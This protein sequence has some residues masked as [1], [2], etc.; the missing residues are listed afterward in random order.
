MK[1]NLN[2]DMDFFSNNA[3]RIVY[4]FPRHVKFMNIWTLVIVFIS[5]FFPTYKQSVFFY[6]SIRYLIPN[7]V[8]INEPILC[9]RIQNS[10]AKWRSVI[11]SFFFCTNM[12]FETHCGLNPCPIA[13]SLGQLSDDLPIFLSVERYTNE[14]EL[15]K[16]KEGKS[17]RIFNRMQSQNNVWIVRRK[18][19][20]IERGRKNTFIERMDY[21]FHF[22]IKN[23]FLGTENLHETW[24]GGSWNGLNDGS[25]NI[26]NTFTIER[27]TRDIENR[28]WSFR[29][30][31]GCRDNFRKIDHFPFLAPSKS[32]IVARLE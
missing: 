24:K 6:Y 15:E 22:M 12:F 21:R 5:L 9:N 19:E 18:R 30:P 10:E 13:F 4:L 16:K 2:R 27:S 3:T 32:S 1:R 25:R 26:Q 28:R 11:F 17:K 20:N 14:T 7:S 23:Y 8:W 31:S 29:A